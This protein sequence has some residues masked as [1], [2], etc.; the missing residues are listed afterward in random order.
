MEPTFWNAYKE[1]LMDIFAMND[2][3]SNFKM[4]PIFVNVMIWSAIITMSI[5]LI[6]VLFWFVN[7]YWAITLW[8]GLIIMIILCLVVG[9]FLFVNN[10]KKDK[11]KQPPAQAP[12]MMQTLPIEAE[13][14]VDQEPL[15]YDRVSAIIDSSESFMVMPCICKKEQGLLDNQAVQRLW[16][17]HQSGWRN[18]KNLVWSIIMFPG[19][20]GFRD[21]VHDLRRDQVAELSAHHLISPYPNPYWLSDF[22]VMNE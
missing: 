11:Q 20:T 12:Q 9:L 22:S 18:H 10:K 8:A 2:D 1:H 21:D 17:Q 6:N 14:S 15:P 19:E 5:P 13:I 4:W 16:Q 3:E 7:L